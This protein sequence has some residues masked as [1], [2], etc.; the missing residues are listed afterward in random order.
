MVDGK[1]K[2]KFMYTLGINRM[3]GV[4]KKAQPM[5]S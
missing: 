5:L 4:N 1:L 2:V 3:E